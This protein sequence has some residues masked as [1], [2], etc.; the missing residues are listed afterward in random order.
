MDKQTSPRDRIGGFRDED[1]EPIASGADLREEPAIGERVIKDDAVSGRGGAAAG[2]EGGHADRSREDRAVALAVD[3]EARAVSVDHLNVVIGADIAGGVRRLGA[4]GHTG[5]GHE[6]R[7]EG[8]G[9]RRGRPILDLK[10]GVAAGRRRSAEGSPWGWNR[11]GFPVNGSPGRQSGTV[12]RVLRSTSI[13]IG[14]A[15]PMKVAPR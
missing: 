10:Q 15:C 11:K 6:R 4:G 12:G 13:S 5:E 3:G 1:A 14:S 7:R 2:A 9:R 8:A